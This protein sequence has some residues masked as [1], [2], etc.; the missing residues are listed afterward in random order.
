MGPNADKENIT[1]CK[2]CGADIFFISYNGKKHPVDAKPKHLFTIQSQFQGYSEN[3][4]GSQ[5]A[6]FVDTWKMRNCYQSHFASCPY[7]TQFRK[8]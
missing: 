2:G 3:D 6:I 7:A 5:K 4:L 8:E 1:Q